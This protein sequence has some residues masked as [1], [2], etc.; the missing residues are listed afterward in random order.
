M[1]M[2]LRRGG[3]RGRRRAGRRRRRVGHRLGHRLRRRRRYRRGRGGGAV[4]LFA[5]CFGGTHT[6]LL[7]CMSRTTD[8]GTIVN[9]SHLNFRLK[10]S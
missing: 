8:A 7:Y 3:R 9:I 10:Q 4:N 5:C 1:G 2:G 6:S